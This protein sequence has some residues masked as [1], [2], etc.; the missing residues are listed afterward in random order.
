MSSLRLGVST[1]PEVTHISA[2]GFWILY[3]QEELFLGFDDFPWFKDQTVRVIANIRLE[4][5]GHF[6]WPDLD[7]DLSVQIIREP[8]KYPI[9][10]GR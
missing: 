2:F 3:Q 7:V 6:Y 10:F 8:E 9:R 4:G 1:K 5:E